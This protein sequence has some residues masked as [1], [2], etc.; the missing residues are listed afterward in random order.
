MSILEDKIHNPSDIK[1]LDDRELV[2]LEEEIRREIIS[3]VSRNGGHLASNL[4]VVELT[5]AL[6]RQFDFPEDKIIW[7]VG[8]QTYTYKI[9][10]GRYH[11]FATLRKLDGLAGFPK[12]SESEYDCF[13]TGHSSTSISAALGILRAEK[14]KGIKRRVI[15]VIG[16]GALTGGMAFE[17][18]ND[19]GQSG[20]DL[21][22]IL[23]DNQ[24]SI[25]RNV[26]G[27]SKHLE[28]VRVSKR[29]IRLKDKTV[30]VLSITGIGK[31]VMHLLEKVKDLLRFIIRPANVIF[32]DLGFRYFG[33]VDGHDIHELEMHLEAIRDL[34]GPV[35]L[36][37]QTRKG[38]GYEFAELSPDKYHGV[39][40][41]E[42]ANGLPAPCAVADGCRS[43]SE[44]FAQAL[45]GLAASDRDI[46]AVSAAMT[47]GTALESFQKSFPDR[48]YDVGIAEQHALTMA[49]GMASAGARPVVAIYS[50][51]LQ[52]AYDQILHDIAL[53]KLHVVICV[54]RAGI[55]GED[56][57]THQGIYD[58]ALLSSIPGMTLLSPRDYTELAAMLRYAVY[59]CSGP[60]AIRYPRGCESETAA[61]YRQKEDRTDGNEGY[62][63][64]PVLLETGKDITLISEGVMFDETTRAAA[65][66]RGAG[67]SCDLID[68]RTIKP[69]EP[70]LILSSVKK[71]GRVLVAENALVVNGVGSRV[72]DLLIRSGICVPFAQAGI[73]DHPLCQGKI[74]QLREKEGM[75]AFSIYQKCLELIQKAPSA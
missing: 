23:N 30:K 58:I 22:V 46:T 49:A 32:E 57:E 40:P 16:D 5:I 65:M 33:P 38:K 10:T 66:L 68:I 53:Q 63:P 9:L 48:F 34:K 67:H 20:L 70:G 12:C 21:L 26:G 74:A 52:R 35:L 56:G 62:R 44:V 36:H 71:T 19:A 69:L 72:E 55:V 54:D 17:A 42:I 25:S 6:L 75:D 27:L 50:T 18:L 59:E 60:A 11:D 15:A 7:D 31:M 37:V 4:G 2:L 8:H 3:V 73:G 51:F 39:A 29:Y 13:N 43:F 61:A 47:V 14:I 24:M 41:F 64:S 45:S 1:L 28:K